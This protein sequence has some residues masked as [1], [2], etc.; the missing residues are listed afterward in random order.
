MFRNRLINGSMNFWQRAT[1]S[2]ATAAS[3][4]TTADRWCGA[5]TSSGTINFAQSSTVPA[6]T[7][8]IYSLSISS[9]ALIA[10]GVGLVEQRIER[11]NVMDLLTGT[12]ITVSFWA[13]QTAGTLVPLAIGIYYPT[14]TVDTFSAQ[15]LVVSATTATLTGTLTRYIITFTLNTTSIATNGLCLRFTTG[16]STVT[17]PTFLLTGIQLE[18]G[19]TASPFET[20]PYAIEQFMCQRYYEQVIA[21]VGGYNTTGLYLR[22]SAFFRVQKRQIASPSLSF[23]QLESSNLG[24]FN[25]DNSNFSGDSVRILVPVTATGDAYGQW[26]VSVATEL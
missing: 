13:A 2:T 4:Y 12:T 14:T 5:L 16:A 17:A 15:S 11:M 10:S 6:S 7:E 21:R 9:A 26:K 1:A 25:V 24:T 8:F 18:K 23:T 3:T 22:G 19:S 20:R